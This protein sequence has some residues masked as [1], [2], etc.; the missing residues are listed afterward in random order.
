[1][2][3]T[4]E[5]IELA[6]K[7]YPKAR[8]NAVQNFVWSAPENKRDNSMNLRQ[9]SLSYKWTVPTIRAIEFALKLEG[10]I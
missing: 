2:E 5:N 6:L 9:D 7:K 10:K 8:A 4:K 1:M 3:K